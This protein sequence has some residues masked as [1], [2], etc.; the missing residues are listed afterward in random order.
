MQNPIITLLE[1]EFSI[2]LSLLILN[3]NFGSLSVEA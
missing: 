3:M 2:V 1:N